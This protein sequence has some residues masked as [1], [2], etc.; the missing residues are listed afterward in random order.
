[1]SILNKQKGFSYEAFYGRISAVWFSGNI[2]ADQKNCLKDFAD[3]FLASQDSSKPMLVSWLAYM[4]ATAY[5]ETAF[6]LKPIAEYGKGKGMKYGTPDPKTGQTYYGRGLVQL[7]W[8]YN[9]QKA[10]SLIKDE[11]GNNVP[12]YANAD[13]ALDPVY[14]MEICVNGMT[15]GWFTGKKLSDYLTGTIT[16]YVNARRIINGTDKAS[17]IASYAEE[18]EFAIRLALGEDVSRAL[19]VNGSKGDDAREMQDMLGV[20]VD[21]IIGNQSITALT[22]FQKAN[23]LDA[24]GKC[25]TNTWAALDKSVYNL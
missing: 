11:K 6:T 23:G 3:A 21:G 25:G 24:D 17:T 8:D 2:N 1:M 7:T 20:S 16:D 4:L 14:A 15:D 10:E 13:L 12:F 18:V 19:I 5:H 22:N 9:Y